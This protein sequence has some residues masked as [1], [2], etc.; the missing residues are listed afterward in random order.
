M[1][2][3]IQ[4]VKLA[5][6]C[7]FILRPVLQ[8]IY[9]KKKYNINLKNIEND[10]KIKQK[11]D[12]FAQH[13]AYVVHSNTDVAILTLCGNLSEVSVYAI[14]SII[15]E[16]VKNVVK[17]LADGIDSA[18]GD[19]IA[20]NEEKNL[21]RNFKAYESVYFTISTI[22]FSATTFLILPFVNLYIREVTDIN[23]IRPTFAYLM[24]F[25][26]FIYIIRQPYNDLVKVSGHFK[27]TRVG[28]WIEAISN[29]II[30][31]LL[32]W[33]YGIIGVAIGTIISMFIRT[34]EFMVYTS[35]KILKRSIWDSLKNIV[36]ISIELILITV[37]INWIP[38]IEIYNYVTW[39]IMAIYI[40][41]V[42]SII[43]LLINSCV[44]R[45]SFK[46][47]F[48]KLIV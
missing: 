31:F 2:A 28:A 14:Y 19:M 17:S 26:K 25:A 46:Y 30:S 36:V 43:V 47:I 29:I 12:G 35:K 32:V 34:I 7:I 15:V 8:N 13:I 3:N 24:V 39:A 22:I 5:S 4:V 11:W 45:N 23:Y 6:S 37:I 41:I 42:S 27:Q 1:K 38:R 16:S 21:N 9:V 10:Y 44:Y 18:F 33:K 40:C 48:K 20:K